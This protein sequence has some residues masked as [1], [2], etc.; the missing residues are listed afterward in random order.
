MNGTDSMVFETWIKVLAGDGDEC[1][2]FGKRASASTQLPAPGYMFYRD[3]SNKFHF[4]C[5]D[6]VSPA[7]VVTAHPYTTSSGWKHVTVTID[8]GA[9]SVRL[10]V[11]GQPDGDAVQLISADCMNANPFLLGANATQYGNF[12]CGDLRA[13]NYGSGGLP[14]DIAVVLR[15]HFEGE[16]G[17][18]GV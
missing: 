13:F 9:G 3:A 15:R 4:W 16:R 1:R 2:I 17:I 7:S 8:R 6:G 11:N 10:Y 5:I 12:A 14:G 18:Y